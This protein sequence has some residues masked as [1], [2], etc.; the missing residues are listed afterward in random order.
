MGPDGEISNRSADAARFEA[1]LGHASLL[2]PGG[3]AW[4]F[5]CAFDQ[6]RR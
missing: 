3:F 1:G 6:R 5:L 4:G 2:L